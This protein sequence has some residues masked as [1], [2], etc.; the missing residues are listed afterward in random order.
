MVQTLSLSRMDP[1]MGKNWIA[2][3]FLLLVARTGKADVLPLRPEIGGGTTFVQFS[4]ERS[5]SGAARTW[6]D[7]SH[8][9]SNVLDDLTPRITPVKVPHKGHMYRLRAGPMSATD[10]VAICTRLRTKGAACLIVP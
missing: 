7:L 6:A 8:Q 10:A 9:F 1:D 4:A 2:V 3:L 5:E